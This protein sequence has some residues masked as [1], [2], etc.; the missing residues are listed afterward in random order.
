MTRK[1]TYAN[2][3]PFIEKKTIENI[4]PGFRRLYPRNNIHLREQI[5][6]ENDN[7][8]QTYLDES[9]YLPKN[10]SYTSFERGFTMAYEIIMQQIIK[11][12]S[13]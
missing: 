12:N 9:K 5:R 8:Y 6:L 4:L 2:K 10:D 7:L 3:L 1:Q 13:K 11:D